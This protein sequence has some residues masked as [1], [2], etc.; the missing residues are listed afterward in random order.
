MN[1]GEIKGN[2]GKLGEQI[3]ISIHVLNI[4]MISINFARGYDDKSFQVFYTQALPQEHFYLE[5]PEEPLGLL[6]EGRSATCPF[7]KSAFPN[8]GCFS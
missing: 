3:E 4:F 2:S 5:G 7:K 1:F 6:K 8:C